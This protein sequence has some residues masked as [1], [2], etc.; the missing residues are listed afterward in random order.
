MEFTK[1]LPVR[2]KAAFR[3]AVSSS[4]TVAISSPGGGWQCSHTLLVGVTQGREGAPGT[5][6]VEAEGVLIHAL[7][8]APRP[9][10]ES[11][12]I[13]LRAPNPKE[14]MSL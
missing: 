7:R 9:A 4:Q 1:L 10:S 13:R 5:L 14:S 3:S 12:P 11:H 6:W 8:C 2:K